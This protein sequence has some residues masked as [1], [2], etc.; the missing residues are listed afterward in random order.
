MELRLRVLLDLARDTVLTPRRGVARLLALN[1]PMEAR[2]IGVGVVVTLSAVLA[3]LA[4]AL[5]P[6]QV[7]TPWD[8][9][10]S[11]PWK[12]ALTQILGVLYMA[13]AMAFV[14]QRFGGRGSFA[15]ALLLAVWMEFILLCVQVVQVALMLLFPLSAQILGLLAF[16]LLLWLVVRFTAELHGFTSLPAVAVGALATLFVSA[17]VAG[18]LMTLLGIVPAPGV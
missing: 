10:T 15:D 16:G 11:S 14:G 4:N 18:I 1:P 2:W 5:F 17:L 13:G 12:M 8:W 6:V 9:L 7:E 3:F